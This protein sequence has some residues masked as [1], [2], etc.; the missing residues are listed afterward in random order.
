M[1]WPTNNDQGSAAAVLSL[2][3]WTMFEV[4]PIL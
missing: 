2:D 4:N 3:Q 1:V